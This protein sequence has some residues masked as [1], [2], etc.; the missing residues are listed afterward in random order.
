[1]QTARNNN[2][3]IPHKRHSLFRAV[4]GTY[5]DA[6]WKVP[7]NHQRVRL[8][9]D[10]A[11]KVG[12]GNDCQARH[13]CLERMVGRSECCVLR[14]ASRRMPLASFSRRLPPYTFVWPSTCLPAL[15]VVRR[16]VVAESPPLR[17]IFDSLAVSILTSL[18]LLCTAK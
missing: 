1:M 5:G 12:T 9:I 8:G 15:R 14:G 17:S 4:N 18:Q 3:T 10:L 11:Q 16:K 13:I 6:Q 2:T 7:Q